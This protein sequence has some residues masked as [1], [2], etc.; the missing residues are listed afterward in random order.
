MIIS[1]NT[2]T[3]SSVN[4]DT[5]HYV[6]DI[7]T[8]GLS[9]RFA[10][11]YMI[12]FIYKA[13]NQTIAEQW[14]CEKDSDEY[15]M[16]FRLNQLLASNPTLYHFNGDQFDMPFIKKRMALYNLICNPYESI[17]IMKVVRPYKKLLQLENIKLKTIEALFGYVR[18][19]PFTGGDLIEVYKTYLLGP[20]E[21]L[22][23]TLLLHNYEDLLGLLKVLSH[24]PLFRLLQAFKEQTVLID[25]HYSTIVNGVYKG[26]FSVDLSE[27][28]KLHHPSYDVSILNSELTITIPVL[29]DNLHY[30]FPDPQNYYYLTNE[31]YAIHKSVGQ[32][33]AKDH[34][35]QA[36]KSNA[37]IKKEGFFLPAG[38]R[39]K[40]PVPLYYANSDQKVCYVSV[41]DLVEV[42][43][44]DH[45]ISAL[46]SQITKAT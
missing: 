12:G 11:I 28:Y 43:G 44:F 8:T 46:L 45:Y 24:M 18:K 29:V 30:F 41:E 23:Q 36:T 26:K 5:N 39:Y 35:I 7:E 9:P 20:D 22:M 38:R 14:F 1:K 37:Y 25:L 34:R 15:E 16:L 17:D 33:V 21:R 27:S 6:I 2:I 42:N 32:F 4:L 13:E 19:D 40:L 10:S 31:D 3:N